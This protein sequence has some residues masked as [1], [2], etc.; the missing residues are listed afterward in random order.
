MI[1][2]RKGARTSPLLTL[3]T[4]LRLEIW[5]YVLGNLN[6][7]IF[8]EQRPDG[9]RGRWTHGILNNWNPPCGPVIKVDG[10]YTELNQ[11]SQSDYDL[12]REIE[13]DSLDD[14][15][16]DMFPYKT[17][18]ITG[19]MPLTTLLKICRSV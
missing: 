2:S 19:K 18:R 3:P 5:K 7:A 4:E 17:L 14:A 15:L 11:R 10:V 9:K 13:I 6:I 1:F 12:L 8:R 16:R